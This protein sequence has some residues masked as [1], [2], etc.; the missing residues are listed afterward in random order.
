MVNQNSVNQNQQIHQTTT[1]RDGRHLRRGIASNLIW[2][3]MLLGVSAVAVEYFGVVNLVPSFG[4]GG[5]PMLDLGI[6]RP[7]DVS[8]DYWANQFINGL[9]KR[10]VISGYPNDEFKPEQSVTRAEFAAMLQSAFP[11]QSNQTPVI[12]KDVSSDSWANSAINKASQAGFFL[13]DPQ[14]K[15]LPNQPMSRVNALVALVR[16]LKLES[17]LPAQKVL[18][19]YKDANQIPGYAKDAIAAATKAGL[20][21]NY[22]DQQFLNP[23][24]PMTRAEAAAFIYQALVHKNQVEKIDSAYIVG[25]S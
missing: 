15:F 16:G 8:K 25:G 9:V 4:R 19:V 2:L 21:V 12:F 14:G 23:N 7:S 5:R 13:G 3:L 10:D 6:W 20:V 1:K 22:P 18:A 11:Q 17:K 24:Q